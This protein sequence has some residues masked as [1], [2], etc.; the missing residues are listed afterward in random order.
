MA[1]GCAIDQEHCKQGVQT[2]IEKVQQFAQQFVQKGVR[3]AVCPA[4]RSIA[5]GRAL[6]L[7]HNGGHSPQS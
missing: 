4:C 6:G 7:C 3:R 5:Q 2:G 1:L